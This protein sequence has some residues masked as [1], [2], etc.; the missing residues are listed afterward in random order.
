MISQILVVC[1]SIVLAAS[2][3]PMDEDLVK[4]AVRTE[5]P[6]IKTA[7]TDILSTEDFIDMI[8]NGVNFTAPSQYVCKH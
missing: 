6:D 4:E 5:Y 7:L 3:L 8:R 1:L 2:A